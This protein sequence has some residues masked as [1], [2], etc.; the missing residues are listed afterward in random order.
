MEEEGEGKKRKLEIDW[1]AV[2]DN[3]EEEEPQEVEV[4]GKSRA[5]TTPLEKM[6]GVSNF[7][8]DDQQ[9]YEQLLSDHE[10]E[11]QIQRQNALLGTM[12]SKM[13]DKGQKIRAKI[14]R[15]EEE[16]ER[17]TLRRARMVGIFSDESPR[18][19]IYL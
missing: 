15:L 16:K 1:K 8:V 17:R 4:I 7:P 5:P 14:K 2:W 3:G 10:L 6:S 12:A 11:V 9:D 18:L 13:R 19:A